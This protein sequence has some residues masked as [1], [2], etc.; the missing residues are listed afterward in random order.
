MIN[1]REKIYICISKVHIFHVYDVFFL[2]KRLVLLLFRE[3]IGLLLQN[4]ENERA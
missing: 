2:D 1:V 3:G 4:T